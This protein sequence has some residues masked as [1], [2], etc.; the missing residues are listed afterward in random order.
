M[1]S[2]GKHFTSQSYWNEDNYS[3]LFLKD[4]RYGLSWKTLHKVIGVR[5]T[6]VKPSVNVL[7]TKSVSVCL[8]QTVGTTNNYSV[9]IS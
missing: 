6:I 5:I 4:K 2:H 9:L 8:L 3:Q 7:E 1:V